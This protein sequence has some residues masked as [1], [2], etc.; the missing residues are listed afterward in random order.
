MISNRVGQD[1]DIKMICVRNKDKY[2]D[3]A[4]GIPLTTNV[5][6]I[7]NDPEIDIVVEVIGGEDPADDYIT[8]ALE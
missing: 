8:R 6:D 5:D 3:V 4:N 2:Q 1:V 7:L